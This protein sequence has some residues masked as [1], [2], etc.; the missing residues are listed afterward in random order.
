LGS[1]V[2]EADLYDHPFH[3]HFGTLK[4]PEESQRTLKASLFR[5]RAARSPSA[6]WVPACPRRH[7]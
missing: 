2:G 3:P 6:L 1:R 7:H 5:G 4:C